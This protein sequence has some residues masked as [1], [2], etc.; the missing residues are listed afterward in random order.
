MGFVELAWW[1]RQQRWAGWAGWLGW[2]DER[3]EPAAPPFRPDEIWIWSNKNSQWALQA[4]IYYGVSNA[5]S[6]IKW[7]LKLTDDF[8]SKWQVHCTAA[9]MNGRLG[10]RRRQVHMHCTAH[11][12][13]I[14]LWKIGAALPGG[15]ALETCHYF[16]LEA[17]NYCCC[18]AAKF[19]DGF[20]RKSET[21]TENWT[22]MLLLR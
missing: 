18:R 8:R 4:N 14:K 20:C 16:F 9:T 6:W 13:S 22:H 11:Y 12:E 2:Q 3:L 19:S 1:K 5:I 7:Q 21:T 17:G 15:L 10:Q